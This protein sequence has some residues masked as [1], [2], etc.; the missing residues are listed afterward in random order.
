MGGRYV[1]PFGSPESPSMPR[2]TAVALCAVAAA[3]LTAA[4]IP[5]ALAAP[6]AVEDLERIAVVELQRCLL[7]TAEGKREYAAAQEAFANKDFVGNFVLIPPEAPPRVNIPADIPWL[8]SSV[9]GPLM[10]LWK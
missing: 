5:T 2:Q 8:T 4:P 10:A 1:A 9:S 3:L 6:T 7:E